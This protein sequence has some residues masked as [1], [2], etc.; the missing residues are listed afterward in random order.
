MPAPSDAVARVKAFAAGLERLRL[1]AGFPSGRALAAQTHVSHTLVAR[2]LNGSALPS[3]TTTL[4]IV[5]ACRGDLNYWEARWREV[6]ARMDTESQ[7]RRLEAA[8]MSP[9][10]PI[11]PAID[12]ADP[13]EAG[14]SADAKTIH[15]RRIALS[16]ERKVLGYVELRYSMSRGAVWARFGGFRQLDA[17]AANR[18]DVTIDVSVTR[19]S[20]G[21][22]DTF[23]QIYSFDMHW[24]DL[25]I[26]D[27][28]RFWASATIRFG[29][30]IVATG[31]TD[32]IQVASP[33]AQSQ[34]L[35]Q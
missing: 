6:Q 22:Q 13:D 26:A 30:R 21:R 34:P 18:A 20:D 15:D 29:D 11:V 27:G 2:A 31:S 5:R 9:P 33:R 10:W 32:R 19:E 17:I 35:D 23:R 7:S 28:G 16:G 14:C 1:A 8:N 12:G 24:S 25:L 3:L 4:E